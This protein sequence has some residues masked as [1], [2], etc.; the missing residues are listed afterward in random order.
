M[1]RQPREGQPSKDAPERQLESA[2]EAM[3]ESEERFRLLVEGVCDLAIFMLAPDGTVAAWNTGAERL[4]GYRAEQIIGQHISRFYSEEDIRAGEPWR[5]LETAV[6]KGRAES[7]GWRVRKDGTRFWANVVATAVRDEAGRL[8][9][10]VTVTRDFSER[11]MTEEALRRSE[12]RYRSIVE[13]T[14]EWAWVTDPA[15]RVVEDIPALRAFTGQSY[16]QARGTGWADALHP[17]DLQ[18]TLE[19]WNRAV[20]AKTSYETEYRMRRHDGV[21]RRLLARGVP[22]LDDQGSVI[23]WV[24]TCIDITERKAAEEALRQSREDLDRAQEVGQIGWWRLDTRRNV[25]TWSDESHRIF[26]VPKGTPLSYDTFL[27]LV[28]PEDRQYV[29]DQWSAGLR[30]APYDIEHRIVAGGQVKWVREKAYLERGPSGELLGGFGITQDITARKQAEEALLRSREGLSR[31]AEGSL[32]IMASTDLGDMSQAISQ[33]ALALTGARAAACGHG[34]ASGQ[35]VVGSAP[36]PDA[37]GCPLGEMLRPDEGGIPRD[38]VEDAESV[39]LTAAQLRAH[40]KRWGLPEGDRAVRGLLGAGIHARSGKMNGVILVADKEQGDFTAE[41]EALLR[42]LATVASLALQHVEARLSLEESDRR[43]DQFLATLSHELRNPLAPL[44]N[45]LCILSRAKPGGEQARRAE[46]VID[47]QVGHLTRLVDDLLDVTRISRGKIRLLLERLD[48]CDLVRRAVEDYRDAFAQNELTLELSL[49]QGALW[50]NA[51]RTRIAQVIGNLLNN[52]A[53]FTPAGGRAIVSV[54][55]DTARGQAVLK[56]R[57]TGIGIAPEMLPQV[58]E[59]FAQAD[60][61]L[62]RGRGGLGLGLAMVKGLVE[63]HGGTAS[64]ESAGLG[65]GA[66]L[67]VRLPIAVAELSPKAPAHGRAVGVR[68]RQRVLVIEDNVDAAETLREVLELD[69]H[70]VQVA[71]S[72]S[73]GVAKARGFGPDV[74]LCDIGLPGI[75]GYEVARTMRRDPALRE[76]RLVALTGYA[77]P[78]DIAAARA[79]GFDAHLAKPL[80]PETIE[81]V[82]SQVQAPG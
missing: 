3:R 64:A 22:I 61:T 48:L 28:H 77:G 54:E 70:T 32:S 38:L 7:E 41:D 15:G 46:A 68:P 13:L 72:G 19:A 82:L 44:R 39:R 50:V 76:A 66:E 6:A 42:Q 49:S 5:V 21:Y 80:S 30:G 2:E 36:A 63:M 14:N 12:R 29:H 16:E 8:R 27:G 45:S 4:K 53:K 24:G 65:Q 11:K 81:Q 20:S 71:F 52:S 78:D 75:D 23:E 31:L 35:Y 1:V 56:V 58:F 43:K 18:R 62:D 67:T 33:T 9:G 55:R 10:F 40:A 60:T 25:L 79:A 17:G 69:E 37:P 59:A 47:R 73:E 34:F 74:V 57:D 26:G 51:D